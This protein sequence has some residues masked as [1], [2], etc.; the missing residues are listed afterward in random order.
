MLLGYHDIISIMKPLNL[1]LIGRSG[2]GKGTQADLLEKYIP[3]MY[4]IE[5]GKLLRILAEKDSDAG[6]RIKKIMEEGSLAPEVIAMSLWLDNISQNVK[7]EQGIIFD[8]A[9]RRLEEAEHLDEILKFLDRFDNTWA[10]LI[11]ISGEEAYKRLKLRARPDDNNEAIQNRMD[12]YTD[13]VLPVANHYEKLEK[14]IRIN[15]E[16]SV[17]KI[18]E[19]IKLALKI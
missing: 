8:G 16:Q 18:H 12:F 2:S 4:H 14:L 1:I 15:G 3:N 11:N 19:D 9:P 10:V 6:L 13:Q 5:S 17:E 7:I